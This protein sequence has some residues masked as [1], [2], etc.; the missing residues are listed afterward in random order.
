M[1][2]DEDYLST[3]PPE[4]QPDQ[5]GPE[6][7]H[8]PMIFTSHAEADAHM[9]RYYATLSTYQRSL[10]ADQT[11]K[12]LYP[13]RYYQPMDRV[14]EFGNRREGILFAGAEHEA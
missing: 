4:L 6:F 11:L 12:E 13:D 3:L 9:E 10:I 2:S 8:Q 5:L 1:S 14:F 7:P